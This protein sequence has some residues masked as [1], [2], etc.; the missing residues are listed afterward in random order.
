MSST[1]VQRFAQPSCAFHQ[2][3][4]VSSCKLLLA[5]LLLSGTNCFA[6]SAM[7]LSL[8]CCAK[9][10]LSVEMRGDKQMAAVKSMGTVV[11]VLHQAVA[12]MTVS[13]LLTTAV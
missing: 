4:W 5:A 13:T 3:V 10:R 7:M 8:V 9:C 2:G 1:I 11:D 12:A 6:C